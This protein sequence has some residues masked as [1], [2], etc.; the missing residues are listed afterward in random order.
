M[1]YKQYG[2]TGIKVSAIGMGC[3]RFNEKD[4]KA[5]NLSKCAEVVLYAHD[6]GI[7]YFDTAP[8]YCLDR[9]EIVTG[10][11]LSQLPRNSY[12]ISSKTN[13]NTLKNDATGDSFRRRLE[14]S[15]KRLKVDYLDFYHLWNILTF[16]SFESQ[17]SKLYKH[18]EKAKEEG[19]IKH[20]V[21]SSH[22]HGEDLE[23]A[24]N[25]SKFDG[26]LLGYNILNYRFR[27]KG[28]ELANKKG[29]GVAV[30]N[31]LSGGVIVRNPDVFNFIKENT[32]LNIAQA[33]LRFVASH[34][35]ISVV[36]NGCSEMSHVDDAIKS[37]ENLEEN[38]MNL[39]CA[40][41]EKRG[42]SLNNLCTGC[43]YCNY[44]PK[45]IEIPKLMDAYNYKLLNNSI[46]TRLRN[47]WHISPKAARGCIEC[48]KCEKLCT[49]HLPI[50]E[51]L[52]EIASL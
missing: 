25:T 27:Q 38:P 44:C 39:I 3:M 32:N 6:K 47:H 52:K 30:M 15:L 43:G 24:I 49:Q 41:Y 50:I 31:P 46:V 45:G 23:D 48:G 1:I 4:I 22:M 9:S 7:N 40:E 21:M 34:K 26:V 8:F 12:Y 16:E 42:V 5:N 36:L 13:I 17:Y 37:V 35:E 14:L 51:R 19:L 18:F 10:I 29:M 33:A 28:I 11:A 2:N 20:I